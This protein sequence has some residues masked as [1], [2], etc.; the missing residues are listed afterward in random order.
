MG[1]YICPL[2]WTQ[3]R[4]HIKVLL[5]LTWITCNATA[6]G[7]LAVGGHQKA[8]HAVTKR[9]ERHPG[10]Y[11]HIYDVKEHWNLIHTDRDVE[12]NSYRLMTITTLHDINVTNV[13]R[14]R[15]LLT[16]L[17]CEGA[18]SPQSHITKRWYG[19]GLLATATR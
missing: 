12:T 8:L 15:T 9:I 3:I 4:S 19:P 1:A 6:M 5:V 10:P 14:F 17:R 18:L 16:Y 2:Y 13:E 7:D 11:S